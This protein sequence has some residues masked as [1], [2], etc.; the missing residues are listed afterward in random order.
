MPVACT[1]RFGFW[2]AFLALAICAVSNARAA[3]HLPSGETIENIDFERHVM[4]VFGR[5][6][7]NSGSCHGSFQGKGGFRLSLFGYDPAKD[8]LALTREVEGRR[9]NRADPDNSLLLLKAA[10]RVPH[11]G[12]TR[13][14][15]DTW[16]YHLLRDWIASGSRW[17]PGSGTVAQ[18]TIIPSEY[19]FNKSGQTGQLQVKASFVDGATETITSLCDFRTN[20][21]AIVEVT[22]LGR[23]RAVRPGDT[24]VIVSYRGNVLPVRVLV[25][26]EPKPGF[27]YPDVPQVNFIDREVFA[28]LRRLN[29][30]PSDLSGDTEFLRRVTIDTIGTLPAPREV[31]RFLADTRADKRA[32]KIDELLAHPMHA[33]LWATKLCD[34]TGNN[35]DALENPGQQKA[36]LSQMWHDWFRKRIADNMPY[37][38]IVRGVLCATSR[39]G[40]S[41]EAYVKQVKQTE[42]SNE[43]FAL[44]CGEKG[45]AVETIDKGINSV[46]AKRS[47]LDLF[48]RRQK[49]VPIEEWGEKT[50]AAFLGVRLQCAQCHKHPFDRWTQGDYRAFA[51]IFSRVS[52]GVSP[53]SQ[54]L[55][56]TENAKRT[57]K[58]GDKKTQPL[59]Q[60]REVF[61]TKSGR[62]LPDPDTNK[63]LPAR[64]LGGSII[65]FES[66]KDPRQSL[67]E[68]M[69]APENPF[70]ARSFV[71]RVWGHYFGTGIVQ[72]VD[73]FSLANP[74]SNDKLLD[75]LAKDF[76]DGKYNIRELERKILL[77]RTYQLAS[78]PNESNR[79]DR[80]NYAHSYIRPMMAEVMVDVLN[81]VLGATEKFGPE[82]P[83]GSRAIEVGA[84]R[85]QNATVNNV[86][87]IFG[88]PPRTTTCDCER[89]LEP[90]LPQKLYLLADPSIQE[91]V[92]SPR[93]RIARLLATTR[94]EQNA[95]DELFLASLSR[96]PTAK[97]RRWFVEYRAKTKDRRSAFIDTLWALINTNEFVFNH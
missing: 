97:E 89:A 44:Q 29:I 30:V 54:S 79:L 62:T 43:E 53:E 75:A 52:F 68:W 46:Y 57:P 4:G 90:G 33:A 63:L 61:L 78:V 87:R 10:G 14:G 28:K 73:D 27:S 18:I 56:R 72:P 32:R 51:N 60:L 42:A 82:A 25:P 81:A 21:E 49:Q 17:Q 55:F 8:Y 40:M 74:P 66:S 91:K 1:S 84:S 2:V 19:A 88:R 92:E 23:L 69:H 34:I 3:V 76:K 93:G 96:L 12:Q 15:R 95:L 31:R 24:A 41:P 36:R 85:V 58:K 47:S 13:F 7:C 6:G 94:D 59:A 64:V 35:T 39:E 37:D 5:M 70:F 71:N 80:T 48:W 77:S 50:A 9:L 38:E 83:D 26:F 20:D 67:F 65:P 16:A 86:F 22:A 11:E 45:S